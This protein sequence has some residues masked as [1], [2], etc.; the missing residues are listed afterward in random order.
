MLHPTIILSWI[1][2]VKAKHK[3]MTLFI[4]SSIKAQL[5]LFLA[6]NELLCEWFESTEL[7]FSVRLEKRLLNHKGLLIDHG[8][9]WSK[10]K[11]GELKSRAS[12]GKR[13]PTWSVQVSTHSCEVTFWW[14][15]WSRKAALMFFGVWK[16]PWWWTFLSE[17]ERGRR[18]GE[19]NAQ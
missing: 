11:G 17:R 19:W 2:T 7:H 10:Y 18:E 14:P 13:G 15:A 9:F 3:L 16:Q 12:S 4:C 5:C 6:K 1:Q 8:L